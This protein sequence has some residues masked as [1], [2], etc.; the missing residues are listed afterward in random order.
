M[1]RSLAFGNSRVLVQIDPVG[2]IREFA[3]PVGICNHLLGRP[4]R[5]G[6]F[7]DGQLSWC[8]DRS[9]THTQ[10]TLS[11]EP[12]A[13]EESWI[14]EGLGVAILVHEHLDDSGF[15]RRL[16]IQNLKDHDRDIHLFVNEQCQMMESATND[17]VV[18]QAPIS[19][20]IHYK[21]G[22]GLGI[23]TTPRPDQMTT[24]HLGYRG[25]VGS[26]ADA[27]DGNLGGNHID[28]GNVDA[29][30]RVSLSVPSGGTGECV[31]R[32]FPT[33][34]PCLAEPPTPPPFYEER[35]GYNSLEFHLA[36]MRTQVASTGAILAAND[37]DVM[38][39]NR[40]NYAS[41]W[42]RDGAHVASL[43]LDA[44][45]PE[46]AIDYHR[47]MAEAL[48]KHAAFPWAFQKYTAQ[49]DLANGWHPWERNGSPIVP[50][51]QDESAALISLTWQLMQAGHPVS[52]EH[53][54]I[55][56]DRPLEFF[57]EHRDETGLPKPSFDLWEERFGVHVYT[58]AMVIRALEDGSNITGDSRFQ[59]AADRMRDAFLQ[60]FWLADLKHFMRRIDE[61]GADDHTVDASSL[62]VGLAGVLPIDDDRVRANADSVLRKLWVNTSIGGIAR[63]EDDYYFR[64]N[65]LYP[66]NPWIICTL[67][68]GQHKA[69]AG[70]LEAAKEFLAWSERTAAPSGILSEQLHPE[71]GAFLS[72]SPLT[73]SHAEAAKIHLL[74]QAQRT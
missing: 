17:C 5:T 36:V 37:S 57:L 32:F 50:F 19:T 53:R 16:R 1:A 63:Y 70:D 68:M 34:Y 13:A 51:Q 6:I 46:V 2:T 11:V 74:L 71:T 9:W 25:L 60:R 69:L 10:E 65:T 44:G 20:L 31:I 55:V 12:L 18:W 8:D 67:W 35:R 64:Q 41:S 52:E 39:D 38:I 22:L 72:V 24:G 21:N 49:G 45:A 27:E 73:W 42:P 14:H 7:V 30:L 59:E 62:F 26:G 61:N 58:V 43:F 48:G 40:L 28:V 23:Q 54:R 33:P 66:G 4:I 47:Y 15:W 3:F 56:V 29:T